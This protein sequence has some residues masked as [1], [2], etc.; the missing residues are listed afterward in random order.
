M[1]FWPSLLSARPTLRPYPG[2]ILGCAMEG[3]DWMS[4]LRRWVWA[5]ARRPFL[6]PWLEGL[7][8]HVGSNDE[9]L[10]SLFL[11]GFFEPNE[12]LLLDRLLRPGMSFVDVGANLGMYTL[13]AAK[14]VGEK[15]AV[16]AIE[17]SS[18]EFQKLRANV[19]L[20]RLSRVRL[21]QMGVSDHP[22]DAELLIA[23]EEH[24]GHNS[25]GGFC[26][27]TRLDRTETIRV[28][29]LD[30]ILQRNRFPKV[31]ILKMDIEGGELFALRGMVRTLETF[32]PLLLLEMSDPAAALQGSSSVQVWDFLSALGYRFH[33]FDADTGLPV[34][35][36]LKDSFVGENLIAVHPTREDLWTKQSDI[37]NHSATDPEGSVVTSVQTA[38]R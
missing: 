2:W 4:K 1:D 28:E 18:R 12:I 22:R 5:N 15:G 32:H 9:L 29:R 14:K 20:N 35:A 21:L 3:G 25:L 36:V 34:P 11:T 37:P 6:V 26:Y 16:L 7:R 33:A 13:F 8:V 10:K 19:E 27:A 23:D 17:P 38:G 30:D 31:D 24:S